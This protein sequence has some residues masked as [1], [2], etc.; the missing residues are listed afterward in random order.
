MIT[1]RVVTILAPDDFVLDHLKGQRQKQVCLHTEHAHCHPD[2]RFVGFSA[3]SVK[4]KKKVKKVSE[5]D[6]GVSQKVRGRSFSAWHCEVCEQTSCFCCSGSPAERRLLHPPRVQSRLIGHVA[7]AAAA[8]G[9]SPESA[10]YCHHSTSC[11]VM[12]V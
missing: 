8:K 1:V 6:L 2:I 12:V 5:E 9:R 4:K 11:Q 10:C 7:M 3:T